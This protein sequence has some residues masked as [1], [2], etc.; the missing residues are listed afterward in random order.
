METV[1][2]THCC[3]SVVFWELLGREGVVMCSEANRANRRTGERCGTR[4]RYQQ[5]YHHASRAPPAHP[6]GD[7]PGLDKWVRQASWSQLK[8]PSLRA[9][10]LLRVMLVG[11]ARQQVSHSRN[12][13]SVAHNY[14]VVPS[15]RNGS[16][17]GT[18]EVGSLGDDVLGHLGCG[19]MTTFA[20]GH[21][22]SVHISL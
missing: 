6:R 22:L 21:S 5:E 19:T 13:A 3:V 7:L 20:N 15:Y 9:R 14:I 12:Q 17:V 8:N 18:R 10:C 16:A 11:H 2:K 1:S 4:T